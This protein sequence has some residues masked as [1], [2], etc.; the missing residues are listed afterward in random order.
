MGPFHESK[1]EEYVTYFSESMIPTVDDCKS[2]PNQLTEVMDL[3]G[4]E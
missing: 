2:A 1:L 3:S 4:L